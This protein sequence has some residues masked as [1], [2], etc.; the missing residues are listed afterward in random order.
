M[1]PLLDPTTSKVDGL[2]FLGL[3]LAQNTKDGHVDSVTHQTAFDFNR[4]QDRDYQYL[5]S[6]NDDGW[7]SGGGEPA[8]SYKLTA[9]DSAH[10]E[11]LRIGTYRPD[12]G[13]LSKDAVINALVGGE[14]LIPQIEVLPTSVVANA[15]HPPELE[16]RFDMEPDKL[17]PQHDPDFALAEQLQQQQ[18]N[19]NESA[20]AVEGA[21]GTTAIDLPP[22][23]INWQLRFL[24]NQLFMRFAYASRFCPGPFHSTI[25][26]KAEFRSEPHRKAYLAKCQKA[27]ADWQLQF[28]GKPQPLEWDSARDTEGIMRVPCHGP[29]ALNLE[30][31]TSLIADE[32][33]QSGL[34]LF[35]DRNTITHHFLPNFLPPYDTVEKRRIIWS[36]LSKQ[37][38]ERTLAWKNA[39]MDPSSTIP[40]S[41][42]PAGGGNRDVNKGSDKKG[43]ASG[44]DKN[45]SR[46]GKSASG[47]GSTTTG[48]KSRSVG[49]GKTHSRSVMDDSTD[50]DLFGDA[51]TS[52]PTDEI[53]LRTM[54]TADTA[55]SATS[56]ESN[57]GA[58]A[59]G[60]SLGSRRG[61]NAVKSQKQRNTPEA[62]ASVAAT[63]GAI[64]GM[65]RQ[66]PATSVKVPWRSS[67]SNR[68]IS[69]SSTAAVAN[70]KVVSSRSMS[71]STRQT[72][73]EMIQNKQQDVRDDVN[74][75]KTPETIVV[76]KPMINNCSTGRSVVTGTSATSSR[77]SKSKNQERDTS[78]LELTR[79]TSTDPAILSVDGLAEA[80]SAVISSPVASPQACGAV[81]VDGLW[82]SMAETLALD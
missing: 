46:G 35:R 9:P 6:T 3:S 14:I 43:G 61:V 16:V 5:Q 32:R 47:G 42:G 54:A 37:W 74:A 55:I 69:P 73:K 36:V 20:A 45:S 25:V 68:P 18:D 28:D 66:Q 44:S 78:N 79:A 72:V 77:K 27:I 60:R 24:H 62:V 17:L 75:S 2:A 22:L 50:I 67:S 1:P 53:D 64:K 39:P 82:K 12:W 19:D 23:P 81:N 26:R 52:S 11:I 58:A 59:R 34:Y 38:C 30:T 21:T 76:G 40:R 33:Y 4:V 31:K 80:M 49:G 10:V 13:G 70:D 56:L 7:L 71:K 41:I 8:D 63:D 57:A 48:G 15:D 29:R 51:E 65:S